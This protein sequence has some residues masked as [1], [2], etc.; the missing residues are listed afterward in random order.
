ME[1]SF[2]PKLPTKDCRNSWPKPT[3]HGQP[4]MTPAALFHTK[5]ETTKTKTQNHKKK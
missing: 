3:D 2:G 4:N 5:R 1:V